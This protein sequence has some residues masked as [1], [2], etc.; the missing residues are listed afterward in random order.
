MT[1]NEENNVD[2]VE[3]NVESDNLML[4]ISNHKTSSEEKKS[5]YEKSTLQIDNNDDLDNKELHK[6]LLE[7]SKLLVSEGEKN[8][9]LALELVKTKEDLEVAQHDSRQLRLVLLHAINN[10][11]SSDI[12]KYTHVPLNELLRLRLQEYEENKPEMCMHLQLLGNR[13]LDYHVATEKI[14]E[15]VEDPMVNSNIEIDNATRETERMKQKLTKSMDNSRREREQKL[16]LDRDLQ[17]TNERIGALSE[18]IEKLMVHLKHEAITKAKALSECTRCHKEINLLKKRSMTME[19][20][21]AIKHRTIDD[22]KENATI[23]ENQLTLM[24]EKYIDLRIK[25]DFSRAQTERV[26]KQK[27][28]EIRDFKGKL[29]LAKQD[30]LAVANRSKKKVRTYWH[31]IYKNGKYCT[32]IF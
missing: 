10:N 31:I 25:L 28:E 26:L 1:N 16:K 24:D 22:L 3:N 21:N 5:R 9:P 6:K 23:L 19:K 18:H 29:L 4:S 8:I 14:I 27:D 32:I 30:L 7:I 11:V 17:A 15:K 13:K 12:D 20:S 2:N